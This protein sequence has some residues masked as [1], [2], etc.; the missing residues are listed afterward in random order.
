MRGELV[1]GR[2]QRPHHAPQGEA[3][4]EDGQVPARRRPGP[5]PGSARR[6]ARTWC[7][8]PPAGRRS[9]TGR[10]AATCGSRAARRSAGTRRAGRGS[11]SSA[12]RTTQLWARTVV[13]R[14]GQR[15]VYSWKVQV[16]QTCLPSDGP[17]CRR[18]PRR[19]SR[20]RSGPGPSSTSRA[21]AAGDGAG[22]ARRR[23]RRRPPAPSSRRAARWPTTDWVMVCSSTFRARAVTHSTKRR[24]PRV[25]AQGKAETGLAR[26]TRGG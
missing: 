11:A 23:T 6:P 10:A 15:A 9:P 8:T 26:G 13:A 19:G 12:P 20:A 22:V 3:A 18:R 16:P 24:R 5:A 4:V 7:G 2:D 21:E 1:L 25:K 14:L 17:W